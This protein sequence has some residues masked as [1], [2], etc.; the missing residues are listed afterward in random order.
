LNAAYAIGRKPV[1]MNEIGSDFVI[2]SGHKSM[3]S[4]GPIGVL[5]LKKRWEDIVLKKSKR[6]KK[7]E[8]ELLG[9]T[10]RG[11]AM[12]TLIAS[13]PSVVERVKKWPEQVEKARW[14]SSELEKIGIKQLGEKPH[15]HDLLFFESPKLYEISQRHK[16]GRFFLYKELKRRG[17]WGIKP[18]LTK[19]FKLST[20]AASKKELEKIIKAFKEFKNM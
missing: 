17:I 8:I 14:F 3:A 10:V 18:G 12:M 4:A 11:V 6:F 5:G 7:K 1:K 19:H 16:N 2:G 9:C 20:F 15:N 13:F